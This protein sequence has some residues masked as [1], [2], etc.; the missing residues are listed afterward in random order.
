LNASAKNM[1][2]ELRKSNPVVHSRRPSFIQLLLTSSALSVGGQAVIEG[3]MMRSPN[4]MAIAVRK[5]DKK[6]LVKEFKWV[7]LGERWP[8]LKKPVIRG[9]AMLIEAMMNGMQAL[10]FSAEVASASEKPDGSAGESEPLTKAAIA[11]SMALAFGVGIFMFVVLPHLLTEWLGRIFL[12]GLSVNTFSFH[13]IDG[14]IKMVIFLVY[15]YV[16]G[17]TKDIKR[18]FQYHGAEHKSIF[19]Y[20]YGLEL[21]VE[22]AGRQSRLHPRCGTAFILTAIMASILFFSSIFP[23]LPRPIGWSPISVSLFYALIK[24]PLMLPIMGVAYEFIRATGKDSCPLWFRKLG[25]PGLWLQTLT[26][27]EPDADQLEVGVASLKAC[28]WR[29]KNLTA[30][31]AIEGPIE[32]QTILS[33]AFEEVLAKSFEH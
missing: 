11:G 14:L 9:A 23:M 20:E 31:A 17:T 32:F 15:I 19:T 26:T 22:N 16:I 33:P 3:V 25:K 10:A 8:L 5:P 21:N 7:S 27:R 30:R 4:S 2:P 1:R 13:L 12:G 24:I 6:I 18:V 28:L 29:E